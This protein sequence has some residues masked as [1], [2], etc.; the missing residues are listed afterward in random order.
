METGTRSLDHLGIVTPVFD[1]LGIADVI[2]SR[3]PKLRQ[4]KLDHS[5]VVK[6]IVST[7]L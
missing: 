6:A 4:H 2:D 3:M 1:Q 5:M 7:V